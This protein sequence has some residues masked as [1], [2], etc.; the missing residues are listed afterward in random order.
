MET[1]GTINPNVITLIVSVAR[2]SAGETFGKNFKNPNQKKTIPK[3]T[4][5]IVSP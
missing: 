3:E 2:F 1:V 4:L 5:S